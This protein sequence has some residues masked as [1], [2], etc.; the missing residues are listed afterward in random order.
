MEFLLDDR[1]E[2]P[3]VE[4]EA[5]SFRVIESPGPRSIPNSSLAWGF[6][7]SDNG[8]ASTS[9]LL[10]GSRTNDKGTAIGGALAF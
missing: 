10:I 1:G 6:A 2:N 4:A 5:T 7:I 9:R 8:F 3:P